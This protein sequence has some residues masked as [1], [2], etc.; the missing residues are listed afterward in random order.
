MKNLKQFM[1]FAAV[2]RNRS[3]AA[4]ARELGLAP[5]SV[6]KSV[7]RLEGDLGIRLFHRTTR[8]LRLTGEGEGLYAQCAH[9]L[10][11]IAAL[12]L[13]RHGPAET[14]AGT[15]RVGAPVAYGT[16]FIVPVLQRLLAAHPLLQA[17][18]RLSDARVDIVKEG[19]DATIRIGALD[20]SGM[21]ARQIGEQ[22]LLLCA[23]A[24]YLRQH[25]VPA[26]VAG[27]AAHALIAFRLPTSGRE[28]PLTLRVDGEEISMQPA[29]RFSTDYGEAMVQ[30][31]L[32]GAG[33]AQVPEHMV[34]AYL[35]EGSLVELLSACRPAPLPVNVVVPAAR[36]MP[37]RVRCL[38]DALAA[39][40]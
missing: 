11:D 17:D 9:I 10:E 14:P 35:Q 6:A 18:L 22:R 28:R 21:I 20:D 33:I 34:A 13:T 15:L 7:A 32:A 31:M 8:A 38:I 3:F 36:M 19:L 1:S 26:T 39:P 4:A 16:R 23:G 25:G 27:L 12:E 5:S 30:A 29:A 24:H 37:S 2:A 40:A